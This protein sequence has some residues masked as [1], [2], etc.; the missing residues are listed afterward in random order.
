MANRKLKIGIV[1]GEVSGDTLGVKLMRSFR[2]QGIDA[3]FEGIGGPQ[4]IAE[5]FNSYY[6]M[7]TL[8]V[9]GI[10]EVLKDLK[11]LFAV[12][13]GLINQWTQ[14]PV[15]I[16]I[17]IDAPDFNL[18]LSKSIKEKNLPIK[19][20]QYVSPSVWAWRQ[21]RVH[22][23]KQ[24]IDLVL[25]LFP[26]EKV[27]YEQYEVPAAFVGH[28]LAK[29]LPLE[30]PIQIA[31]Q[32]LGVDENQKHIA[33]LPGS[34]KGEVERL[35]PMLLGAANILHTKY[36]D[37]QFL[38]PAINDA[39]KQQIEQGVE[40]LAPQLKAK[41]HILENTDS[42]SKIG[43]M[44]MNASDII[45]LASGTATLEAM[46]MHR[47]MVTFYKLHWLTYLI[48]KFLVK[49]PYY[50]LPNIIAGKKVIEELIQADAT[51]ENLAAEIEKLMNVETAQIQVMQ[52]LTMHKQLI[53]GNTEDPVQA[54]LQCLNS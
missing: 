37:I 41:I 39:R 31:K 43:R 36:P 14:H 24:S 34:R 7:E 13:D 20:V 45:A 35:L 40:Q 32:E 27:F 11:K 54:I 16:F 22:G 42:E 12:R 8:S 3:E 19:T 29:Q 30:N 33:L 48:A 2:E 21:G 9:M 47:P 17:G 15:D 49:I 46:L 25:C 23:I 50:S 52:H 1:V 5:G 6:P 51:P 53:S 28:P 26:F 4:M 10:V 44:V 18:R 38:I